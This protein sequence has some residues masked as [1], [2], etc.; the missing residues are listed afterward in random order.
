MCPKYL[1]ILNALTHCGDYRPFCALAHSV[2]GHIVYIGTSLCAMPVST[3]HN[4]DPVKE[5]E[6]FNLH[7]EKYQ[8]Y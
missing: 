2:H 4:T 8:V 3:I 6:K 1:V 7:C 5:T